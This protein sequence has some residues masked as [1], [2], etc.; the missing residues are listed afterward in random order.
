MSTDCNCCAHCRFLK[1][2]ESLKSGEKPAK[3][4]GAHSVHFDFG[5]ADAYQLLNAIEVVVKL[6]QKDGHHIGRAEGYLTAKG[7][8]GLLARAL[9]IQEEIHVPTRTSAPAF[10]RPS[11]QQAAFKLWQEIEKVHEQQTDQDH[12]NHVH[13]PS[14]R[15]CPWT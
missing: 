6:L 10:G 3:V 1:Y 9:N 15:R 7:R 2:L 14:G 5:P 4:P 12:R 11:P 13:S 8:K